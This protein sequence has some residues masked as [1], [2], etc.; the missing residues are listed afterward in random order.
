MGCLSLMPFLKVAAV[1]KIKP[2]RKGNLYLKDVNYFYLSGNAWQGQLFD[3]FP[4][5]FNWKTIKQCANM[6]TLI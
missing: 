1:H 4:K 5:P 3:N 2:Q 6:W